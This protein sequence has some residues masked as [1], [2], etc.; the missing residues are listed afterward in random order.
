MK[1][2]NEEY[3]EERPRAI[4]NLLRPDAR[5]RIRK[6]GP[7]TGMLEQFHASMS[8][9]TAPDQWIPVPVVEE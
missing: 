9:T 4:L 1:L 6:T 3:R 8:R 2:M 5:F 7:D